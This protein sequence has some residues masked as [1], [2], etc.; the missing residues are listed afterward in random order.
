MNEIDYAYHYENLRALDP[1]QLVSDLNLSTEDL[2]M[3]F[4][5]E[6]REFIEET[7]G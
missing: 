1:D 7:F 6:V 5:E 4:H 2:L 3:H